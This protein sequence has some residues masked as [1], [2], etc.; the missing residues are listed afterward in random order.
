[1][2][3]SI[4]LFTLSDLIDYLY[5]VSMAVTFFLSGNGLLEVLLCTCRT[6]SRIATAPAAY[7][8]QLVCRR[9]QDWCYLQRV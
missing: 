2:K 6:Y 1:V 4:T 9:R 5:S 7:V 8:G 3:F